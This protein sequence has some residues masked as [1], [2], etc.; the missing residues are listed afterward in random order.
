MEQVSPGDHRDID[1]YVESLR[2]AGYEADYEN[3]FSSGFSFIAVLTVNGEKHAV[4]ED[5]LHGHLVKGVEKSLEEINE[6]G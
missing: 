3:L 5:D 6:E 4:F 2:D 1:E